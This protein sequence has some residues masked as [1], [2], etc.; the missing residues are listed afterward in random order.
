MPRSRFV[1]ALIAS[2]ALIAVPVAAGKVAKN[3]ENDKSLGPT[4]NAGYFLGY[5]SPTY[6]WHGCTK[7][8]PPHGPTTLDD[9]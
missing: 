2:S 3:P 7:S 9:C 8:H 4:K 5:P 1:L 6:Q